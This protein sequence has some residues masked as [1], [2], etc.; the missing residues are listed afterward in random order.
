MGSAV[1]SASAAGQA[2][3]SYAAGGGGAYSTPSGGAQTGGLG[4][5]GLIIITEYL[6]S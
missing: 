3:T 4:A 1:T 5:A 6:K 2:G